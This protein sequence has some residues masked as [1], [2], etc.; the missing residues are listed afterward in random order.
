MSDVEETVEVPV[1]AEAE[2]EAEVQ[3]EVEVPRLSPEQVEANHKAL[4]DAIEVAIQQFA[5]GQDEEA[6]NGMTEKE[7]VY[8]RLLDPLVWIMREALITYEHEDCEDCK[9]RRETD[10][11]NLGVAIAEMILGRM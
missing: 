9:L 1:E 5:Y 10:A 8:T 3:A 4:E 7:Q 11:N 2:A 6:F